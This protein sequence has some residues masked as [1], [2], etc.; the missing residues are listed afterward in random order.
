METKLKLLSEV[1]WNLVAIPLFLCK[2]SLL[3]SKLV[4]NRLREGRMWGWGD[5]RG[6]GDGRDDERE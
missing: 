1:T 4:T 2:L 3:L 6:G 5:E